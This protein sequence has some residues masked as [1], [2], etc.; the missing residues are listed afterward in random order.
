ME[1]GG[2][3]AWGGGRTRI[4]Q[5]Q[6]VN[7]LRI[8]QIKGQNEKQKEMNECLC[9]Y[10]M[11]IKTCWRRFSGA[12]TAKALLARALLAGNDNKNSRPVR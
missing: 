11:C 1:G 9:G 4:A 3:E 12:G 8:A 5:N 10:Y 7:P 2:M 6:S